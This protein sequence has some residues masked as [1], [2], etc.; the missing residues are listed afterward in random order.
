MVKGDQIEIGG[1]ARPAFVAMTDEELMVSYAEGDAEAMDELIDRHGSQLLGF[2]IRSLGSREKGEDAYQDVFVKVVRSAENYKPSARFAAWLYT[3]A[4]NVVIDQ[5]RRDKHRDA[6]SLDQQAYQEGA[7][8]KL[9]LVPGEGPNPE[10]AARGMELAEKMEK[11]IS[12]LPE[13]QR[14]VFLLRERSGLSFKEIAEMT[15]APL[16]TVKTRMH[17]ALQRLRKEIAAQGYAEEKA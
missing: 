4:R 8:T 5:V 12:G 13:E 10:E 17:Y 11:A 7:A 15:G 3:I 6:E 1:R 16:N 14:E 9:D 2:L